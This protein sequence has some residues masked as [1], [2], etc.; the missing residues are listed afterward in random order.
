MRRPSLSAHTKHP[1]SS[2]LFSLK[3]SDF[4]SLCLRL[5]PGISA[6]AILTPASEMAFS[7]LLFSTPPGVAGTNTT[8]SLLP[9]FPSLNQSS[10]LLLLAMARC[11]LFHPFG[12]YSGSSP[13]WSFVTII[14]NAFIA[15]ATTSILNCLL[16]PQNCILVTYSSTC[17]CTTAH[18]RLLLQFLR[19]LIISGSTREADHPTSQIVNKKKKPWNDPEQVL[20]REATKKMLAEA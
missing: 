6:T 4:C 13:F 5:V 11:T 3:G 17:L 7:Y 20:D 19:I 1:S 2:N 12:L 14:S 16:Y 18:G 8:L 9:S 15:D 10:F